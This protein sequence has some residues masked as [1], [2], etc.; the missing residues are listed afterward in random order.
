MRRR[1]VLSSAG[2]LATLAL[3]GCVNAG[4][5]GPDETE[6]D[7]PKTDDLAT[8]D[9]DAGDG[10]F[11]PSGD[12]V[13]TPV[14]GDRADLLFPER[15]RPHAV[16]VWNDADETREL[17]LVVTAD[18]ETTFDRSWS[19]PAD[20]YVTL[21]LRDAAP[22]GVWVTLDGDRGHDDPLDVG[23]L[24]CNHSA[25]KVRVAPDGAVSSFG[26][27]TAMACTAGPG[28]A[29][30]AFAVT[31]SGCAGTDADA[32]SAT[33]GADAVTVAGRIS[34]PTPCHGAELADAAWDEGSETLTLTVA[35]TDPDPGTACVECVGG[36]DY[37]AT[38]AF[39]DG[40]PA[41]VAVEHAHFDR[42]ETV[43]SADRDA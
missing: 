14:I 19:V 1:T 5:A 17:G 9:P 18:G 43:A 3:A 31:D 20:R 28:V 13:A 36:I 33:F 4:G 6:T 38:V 32:V 42:R 35:T 41:T 27:S 21:E 7:P 10:S 40:P 16:D 29:D 24:D 26:L 23:P 34:A 11:D 37:E 30:H 8:L 2:T 22:D 39:R 15:Q 12:P 25:T